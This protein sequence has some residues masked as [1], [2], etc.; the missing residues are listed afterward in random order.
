MNRKEME[1][2]AQANV[3]ALGPIDYHALV[4][5]CQRALRECLDLLR[6]R[7]V[8][9]ELPTDDNPVHIG[10]FNDEDGWYETQGYCIDG[11]MWEGSAIAAW[12]TH[13]RPI[14]GPEVE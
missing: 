8:S 9:E 7:K 6:W 14:V 13:W 12:A 10:S 5:K 1:A 11:K 2:L 3:K 4:S